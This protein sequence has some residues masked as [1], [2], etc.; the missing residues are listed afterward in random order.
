MILYTPL[1]QED[2]YQSEI[3]H[4]QYMVITYQDKPCYAEK[5]SDGNYRLI[6]LLS[7]DP[8]DYLQDCF[9]PGNIIRQPM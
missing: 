3:N 6:Q 8:N 5:M 2:I 7:T 9:S 4:E 1:S